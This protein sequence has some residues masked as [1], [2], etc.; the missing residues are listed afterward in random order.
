VKA[1]VVA[2]VIFLILFYNPVGRALTSPRG[3]A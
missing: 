2:V 3:R 1:E